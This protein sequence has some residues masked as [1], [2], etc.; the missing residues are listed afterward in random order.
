MSNDFSEK[1][2]KLI[3][4][5]VEKNV[6]TPE[7]MKYVSDLREEA[8]DLNRIVRSL[9]KDKEKLETKNQALLDKSSDNENKIVELEKQLEVFKKKETDLVKRELELDKEMLETQLTSEK[10]KSQF[11]SETINIMF[12]NPIYQESFSKSSTVP[13]ADSNGYVNDRNSNENTT[14]RKEVIDSGV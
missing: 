2:D 6:F 12:K 13:V 1:L 7:M 5:A 3:K 8:D 10:S 4:G 9:E 11:V 14:T